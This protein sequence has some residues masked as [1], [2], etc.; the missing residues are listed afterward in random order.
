MGRRN[1]VAVPM[2]GGGPV[3]LDNPPEARDVVGLAVRVKVTEDQTS[4]RMAVGEGHR[5]P[6]GPQDPK[7][8]LAI[9]VIGQGLLRSFQMLYS[10]K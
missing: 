5:D 4:S 2:L 8:Q 3:M 6:W 7:V 10:K 1:L 9:A